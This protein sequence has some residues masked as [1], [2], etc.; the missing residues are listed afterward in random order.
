MLWSDP[1]DIKSGGWGSPSFIQPRRCYIGEAWKSN[2]FLKS[3]LLVF[4][5]HAAMRDVAKN[6]FAQLFSIISL[7]STGMGSIVAAVERTIGLQWGKHKERGY[8]L[9][10]LLQWKGKGQISWTESKIMTFRTPAPSHRLQLYSHSN[11]C[12]CHIPL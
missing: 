1:K 4:P 8:L 2:H 11:A 5:H 7:K 9:L 12:K 10:L 3:I 6:T